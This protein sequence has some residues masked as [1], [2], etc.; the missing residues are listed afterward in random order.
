[1]TTDFVLA[2]LPHKMQ[3]LGVGDN[4]ALTFRELVI[5]GKS[6]LQ[7]NAPGQFYFL[8]GGFSTFFTI[9]S[10]GGLYDLTATNI[11]EQAHEHSG[12][13]TIENR[14]DPPIMLQFIVVIP[15]H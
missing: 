2:H 12:K 9:T 10:E 3:E 14:E 8:V 11:N 4:Y 1:M 7:I 13:I 5:K 15:N 6:T